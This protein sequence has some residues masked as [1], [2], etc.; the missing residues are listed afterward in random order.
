M[1]D[2]ELLNILLFNIVYTCILIKFFN[3]FFVVLYK[4]SKITFK[5]FELGI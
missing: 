4:N 5:A 2:K 3:M 1:S